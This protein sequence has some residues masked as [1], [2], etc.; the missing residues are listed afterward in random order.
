MI[1]RKPSS[2]SLQHHHPLRPATAYDASPQT[3]PFLCRIQQPSR[4]P[5]PLPNVR[6]N[7]SEAGSFLGSDAT[8]KAEITCSV[9]S[10]FP[11]WWG[12]G[13]D[14]MAGS[15]GLSGE[16]GWGCVGAACVGGRLTSPEGACCGTQGECGWLV[17]SAE[18][19][20]ASERAPRHQAGFLPRE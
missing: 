4:P 2:A 1:P 7:K 11:G 12:R 20:G 10:V 6:M 17:G 19:P 9:A 18:A 3:R 5:P 13:L 15:T 14:K 8:R 16:G